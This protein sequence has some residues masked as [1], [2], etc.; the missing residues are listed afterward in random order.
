MRTGNIVPTYPGRTAARY[1]R[2]LRRTSPKNYYRVAGC[3][4]NCDDMAKLERAVLVQ[5]NP[6]AAL[7]NTFSPQAVRVAGHKKT[8]ALLR[9]AMARR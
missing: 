1:F 4:Q 7:Q 5:S 9:K 3:C 2:N 8:S 6:Y